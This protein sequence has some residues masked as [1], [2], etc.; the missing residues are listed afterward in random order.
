MSQLPPPLARG[1]VGDA[2][3]RALL[4]IV[5]VA[6]F[7]LFVRTT[8]RYPYYYIWDMDQVT[9][10]DTVL[11]N[12]GSLPDHFNH[13]SFGMYLALSFSS[14][15]AR[16]CSWVSTATLGD[17]D[18]SLNPL[19]GMAE[20]TTYLRM[21]T[22]LVI[23]AAILSLWAALRLLFPLPRTAVLLALLALGSQESLFYQASMIRTEMWSICFFCLAAFAMALGARASRGG[24]SLLLVSLAGLL[25]A[26]SFLTKIQSFFLIASFPLLLLLGSSLAPPRLSPLRKLPLFVS[27]ATL[28]LFALFTL[29]AYRVDIPAGYGT[30]TQAYGLTTL[31]I[32][33]LAALAVL[34]LFHAVALTGRKMPEGLLVFASQATCLSA[35]FVGA[36]LL[37]LVLY[38][39][40]QLGWQHLLF[41]FKVV[42]L[43]PNWLSASLANILFNV[44]NLFKYAQAIFCI[45][46][47]LLAALVLGRSRGALRLSQ[48]QVLLCA[49]LT[50]LAM[51]HVVF[52]S[53]FLLRD[54]LWIE[55]LL[56]LLTLIFAF[57]ILRYSS[58]SRSPLRILAWSAIVLLLAS[59][60]SHDRYIAKRT[61]ANLNLY[62]WERGRW[63]SSFFHLNQAKYVDLMRRKYSPEAAA[64]ARENTD[65]F[66]ANRRL[67]DF[68]FQNQVITQ[69]NIGLVSRGFAVR[70]D[71]PDLRIESYPPLLKN[72]IV[73]DSAAVPRRKE[74]FY[75]PRLVSE[76][77]EFMN[78]F[79]KVN[80]LG[81]L[82]LLPRLDLR[83]FFFAEP[84]DLAQ[85]GLWGEASEKLPIA[86]RGKNESVET[87]GVEMK[88]Y[89]N[90]PVSDLTGV[91]FFVVLPTAI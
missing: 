67:A 39:D 77:A 85:L 31:V 37:H 91:Y 45:H 56:N 17:L 13:P 75:W 82:S 66:A 89:Q 18:A 19:A 1:A 38:R 73:I 25:L 26:L 32:L 80:D 11:I 84:D 49:A 4:G 53:R 23:M 60:L 55:M 70:A 88:G 47:A 52:G 57:L 63:F 2:A 20:L 62:G 15:A 51:L 10:V 36:F 64:A 78:K 42:F 81:R 86:L 30:Y 74:V 90:M 22:P 58:A 46:L 72:A 40:I 9:A 3:F 44:Y 69:R 12:S 83:L 79:R 35:G 16:A 41:D 48:Q 34:C 6:L 5:I 43:R 61:D 29:F 68:V 87:Y 7:L 65:R 28:L 76:Q 54:L 59:N 33:A 8:Q 27:L 14:R 24:I 71:K 50:G 21:H